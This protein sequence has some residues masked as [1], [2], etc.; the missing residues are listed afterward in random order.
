MKTFYFNIQAKGGAGKSMLTYLQA[1]KREDDK[2]TVFVD[3]DN[4]TK[5]S[6]KQLK[7]LGEKERLIT[8]DII[9]S[10]NRIE[11]EKVFNVL[12][13]LN[14]TSFTEFYLDFGAPESEQLPSLFKMDFTVEEFKEF[15][16]SI[17]AKFVFNIVISGGPAYRSCMEY[18]S[19]VAEALNGEFDVFLF[20]NEFTFQAYPT[21][22]QEVNSYAEENKDLV[23]GVCQF[24][25]ISTDRISGQN[26]MENVKDGKGFSSY[27]G[28]ATK[29]IMKRELQKV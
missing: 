25:N 12:E 17:D 10:F 26:I 11:R 13:Q 3:L 14:E 21:L 29:T 19:V 20:L 27:T 5:T 4:S 28:F 24:G 1:L 9:D 15:E 7:F 23:K 8:T 18:A 6:V 22:L 2:E 16:Q